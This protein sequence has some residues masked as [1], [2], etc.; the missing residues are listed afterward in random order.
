M[1]RLPVKPRQPC[2][3][4]RCLKSCVAT[5]IW[6][7]T[8]QRLSP[9][10]PWRLPSS[11]APAPSLCSRSLAGENSRASPPPRVNLLCGALSHNIL[12]SAHCK[13]R[14]CCIIIFFYPSASTLSVTQA[15]GSY[16]VCQPSLHSQ[17]V[18]HLWPFEIWTLTF[19]ELILTPCSF[20]SIWAFVFTPHDTEDI[21]LSAGWI[22]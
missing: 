4:G 7:V 15:H 13:Q 12:H 2:S 17:S 10:V 5:L 16:E 1:F 19:Y 18:L 20:L 11:A 22:S 14:D 21:P 3:T 9:L 6:P 8:P